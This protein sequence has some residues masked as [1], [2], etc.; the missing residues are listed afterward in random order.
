MQN[1]SISA[2]MQ[3]ATV[4]QNRQPAMDNFNDILLF[5]TDIKTV[6]DEAMLELVLSGHP[7]ISKWNVDL[8][9][10]DCVLRIVSYTLS[11]EQVIHM[12]NGYG[13]FCCELT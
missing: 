13:Y 1:N 12:I 6:E 2:K 8:E 11:H 9:D 7:D 5:K 4:K 3:K 10:I